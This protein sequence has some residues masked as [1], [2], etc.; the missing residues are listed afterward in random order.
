MWSWRMKLPTQNLLRL[1]LLPMLMMGIMMATVCCRFGSLGLVIKLNFCSE[2]EHM[3]WSRFWSWSSGK[4]WSW[5][6][7]SILM[8]MFCSGYEVELCS[9]FWSWVWSIFWISTLVEMMMFGQDFEVAAWLILWRWNLIKFCVRTCDMNSTLRSV[10]PLA[11][12]VFRC[13]T[14]F[15]GGIL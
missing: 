1:L 10:V 6:L 7:D 13:L 3:V 2:F 14:T 15:S 8:L 11:M 4:I 12:F 9:R 5:G